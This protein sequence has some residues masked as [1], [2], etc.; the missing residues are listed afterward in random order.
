MNEQH[1]ITGRWIEAMGLMALPPN[2][3]TSLRHFSGLVDDIWYY[4]GDTSADVSP[5]TNCCNFVYK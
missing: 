4:A 1:I 2:I 5:S 3:P